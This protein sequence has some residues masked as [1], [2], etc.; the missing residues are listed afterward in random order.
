MQEIAD[1]AGRGDL[2]IP[3]AKTP[4]LSQFGEG[5]RLM[6]AVRIGGKIICVP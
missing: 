3:V 4:K 5:P 6:D 2:A 1:A